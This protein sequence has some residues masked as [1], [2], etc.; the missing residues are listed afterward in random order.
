MDSVAK[1]CRFGH[2]APV[3]CGSALPTSARGAHSRRAAGPTDALDSRSFEHFS[4]QH[5]IGRSLSQNRPNRFHLNSEPRQ[6][7]KLR[8]SV[9]HN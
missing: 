3:G 6:P 1:T 9:S 8:L 5:R 4:Q 7:Q 2:R